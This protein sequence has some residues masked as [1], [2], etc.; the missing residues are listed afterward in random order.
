MI[1]R[2][3]L[4]LVIVAGFGACGG[5]S[6][7]TGS[8]S[9][10]RSSPSAKQSAPRP[11]RQLYALGEEVVLRGTASATDGTQR[12]L[13]LA[14]RPRR[15][16]DPADNRYIP[17]ASVEPGTRWV[18]VLVRIENRASATYN[19]AEGAFTIID[20]TGEQAFPNLSSAPWRAFGNSKLLS[21][22]TRRGWVAFL[23]RRGN[24]VD[25]LRWQPI[26]GLDPVYRWSLARPEGE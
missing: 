26:N 11:E 3:A 20:S 25:E 8:G 4:V 13:G 15:L 24:P 10:E 21:D 6:T 23:V 5:E 12:R 17:A 19:S 14:V 9:D 2:T 7:D 18:R 16:V 22:D 1:S